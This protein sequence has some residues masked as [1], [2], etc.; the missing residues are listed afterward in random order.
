MLR[1]KCVTCHR[2][3]GAGPFAFSQVHDGPALGGNVE[4]DRAQ[5]PHAAARRRPRDRALR[6]RSLADRRREAR[7]HPVDRCGRAA[8]RGPDPLET[9]IA[10]PPEWPDGAP[11]SSCPCRRIRCRPPASSTTSIPRCPPASGAT[12]GCGASWCSRARRSRITRWRSSS[13]STSAV[14]RGLLP[15]TG[16]ASTRRASTSR[17]AA[18]PTRAAAMPRCSC[19]RGRP[20]IC[21][22]ITRRWAARLEHDARGM[23]FHKGTP[24]IASARW[25]LPS[26][27]RIPPR[28]PITRRRPA[29][30]SRTTSCSTGSI[31]TCTTAAAAPSSRSTP[32]AGQ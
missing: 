17:A 15:T 28:A 23:Y 16:S 25:A 3:Q 31:P 4:G 10:A 2:P 18:S 7:P 14:R 21:R 32:R 19:R 12:P 29:T 24:R 13:R 22:C 9:P 27:L 6:V 20:C 8:G 26:D 11:I 30:R 5:R 1:E